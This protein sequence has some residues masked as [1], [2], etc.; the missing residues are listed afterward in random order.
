MARARTRRRFLECFEP[1]ARR[2]TGVMMRETP[3]DA[4]SRGAGSR[5]EEAIAHLRRARARRARPARSCATGTRRVGAGAGGRQRT[6]DEPGAGWAG[7]GVVA[8]SGADATSARPHLGPPSAR[9]PQNSTTCASPASSPR[10]R[11]CAARRST[12]AKS[13]AFGGAIPSARFTASETSDASSNKSGLV[14]LALESGAKAVDEISNPAQSPRGGCQMVPNI[15]TGILISSRRRRVVF[16]FRSATPRTRQ[17]GE[18]GEKDRARSKKNRL[19]ACARAGFGSTR[20][21][22]KVARR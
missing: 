22:P 7:R 17:R 5:A 16:F 6:R 10:A 14:R 19:R 18:R 9:R 15:Q 12:T 8:G 2:T 3:T 21:P 11:A 1:S 20:A 13:A 4:G